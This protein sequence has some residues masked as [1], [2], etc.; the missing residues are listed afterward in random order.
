[1]CQINESYLP[2]TIDNCSL[3]DEHNLCCMLDRIEKIFPEVW[4]NERCIGLEV[5]QHD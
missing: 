1:M 2:E 3:W 4:E 5:A